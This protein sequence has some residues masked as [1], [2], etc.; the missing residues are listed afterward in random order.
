MPANTRLSPYFEKCCLNVSANASYQR[1]EEDLRL[2]TGI[3]I[4]RST[5]QRLTQRREWPEPELL[6]PIEELS[7]D[8]GMVRLRTPQGQACEWRE[9]K[10]LAVH[11]QINIA[12]YKENE[13]L[14]NWVNDQPLSIPFVCLGDGHD[15]VWNLADRMGEAAH[16][17][18]ILDWYHLM[19]N[20]S[21]VQAPADV[22][23]AVREMLWNGETR[24]AIR[25]LRGHRCPGATGFINYLHRHSTR[26]INYKAWQEEG[27][28]I[29][30]GQVESLV[31]QIASRLKLN[32]AQWS[33]K[34]VPKILKHRCAYLNGK[35]AA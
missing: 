6:E 33:A 22:L 25:Y 5:L 26:I 24:D 21:K 19:E 10:A 32:G 23:A 17:I 20:A 4:S 34:S 9:Y 7:L 12:F 27:R 2:L 30:S 1:A 29:G 35:L 15:G 31:K 13:K 18:E 28:S 3:C 11:E 14:V 8:G 16:R